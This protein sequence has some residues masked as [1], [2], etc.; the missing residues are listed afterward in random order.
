MPLPYDLESTEVLID[1]LNQL[2]RRITDLE[3][4]NSSLRAQINAA[5]N[6]SLDV[7]EFV[8]EHWPKTSLF[9]P[10]FWVRAITVYGHYFV[11]QLVISG[12]IFILWLAVVGPA[13]GSALLKYLPKIGYP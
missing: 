10:S 3:A 5:D 7:I 6:R 8:K 13:I 11:I 4:E 1:F 12:L 9:S 2:E